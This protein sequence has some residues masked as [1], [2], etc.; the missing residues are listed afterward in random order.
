M[1]NPRIIP[2]L[3]M[4]EG[5]LVKTRKF[6]ERK[7][8]GDPINAVKIFNEKKV[9]ELILLDI[10]ASRNNLN[11][12]FDLISKIASECRMPLCYGGGISSIEDCEKLIKLG[13][14]KVAISSG[15]IN[16]KL[17]I[18]EIAKRIGSQSLV[19][20][21]DLKKK[22]TN[23]NYRIY[24]NNGEKPSQ[25]NLDEIILL[26]QEI[27]FGEILINS[28]DKDGIMKGYDLDLVDRVFKLSN[29][30][31]TILGGA[32]CY[33]DFSGLFNKYKIIGAAAGS[34]FVFKG[35][36]RAVLIQYPNHNEKSNILSNSIR[37]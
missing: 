9:D 24:T 33:K 1:L 2:C 37:N 10:D 8:V 5:G 7:Y 22:F 20:V 29:I 12:N 6:K 30:P 26:A 19:C 21:L 35:K 18:N 3:L 15:F 17:N 23:K 25:L 11:P 14:E 4:S 28:I 27:G 34:L 13:V 31:L 32:G 16:K 36:Y